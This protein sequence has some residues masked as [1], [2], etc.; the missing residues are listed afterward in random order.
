MSASKSAC[1]RSAPRSNGC[2]INIADEA[3]IQAYLHDHVHPSDWRIQS[4][5]RGFSEKRFIATAA[6]QKVVVKLGENHRILQLLS[7][8]HIT[9]RYITGGAFADTWI[10]VQEFVT[11]WHPDRAWFAENSAVWAALMRRLHNLTALRQYLPPV[12][13]ETYQTLLA[14][15]VRQIDEL[16][17]TTPLTSHAQQ[18]IGSLLTQY[19]ARLPFIQGAGLVPTQ[20]DPNRDN[21]LITPTQA[22]LIDWDALHLSDPMRDVA[23]ILWWYYPKQEWPAMCKQFGIDLTDS[24][25]SE[26]FHLYIST[27]A[28]YVSLFFHQIHQDSWAQRFLK[29]AQMAIAHQSPD[30][31]LA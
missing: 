13:N 23:Q 28:L 19:A 11:A 14:T 16:S 22:Y 2:S 4:P 12:K 25:Q 1:A 18:Q 20:G 30:T 10:T 29:D 3:A 21:L 15:Y 24:C 31:L 5:E 7:D 26:R 27:R 8:A 6:Q 17:S 9:P